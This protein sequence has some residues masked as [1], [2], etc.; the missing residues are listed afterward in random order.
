MTYTQYIHSSLGKIFFASDGE[1]LTGLWFEGQKYFGSTLEAQA[2]VVQVPQRKQLPIFEVTQEWIQ[3]YYSGKEPDFT[4][5]LA[6]Q[7]THFQKQV[8]KALLEIPFGTT[9]SYGA[10]A[11]KLAVARGISKISAQAVGTAVGRNPISIIVPCHRVL[12]ADGSL[13]GY[14]A[15]T[16]IKRALLELEGRCNE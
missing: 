13:T 12:G 16:S 2:E 4:P 3:V 15:G 1:A 10:I 14:A 8:W 11:K 6:L 9:T 7:G 5:K